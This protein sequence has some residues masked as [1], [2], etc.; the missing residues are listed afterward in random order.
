MEG[1]RGKGVVDDPAALCLYSFICL[2]FFIGVG[3]DVARHGWC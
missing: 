1:W 3:V 2:A